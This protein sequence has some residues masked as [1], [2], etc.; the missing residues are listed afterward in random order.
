MQHLRNCDRLLTDPGGLVQ[1]MADLLD[2]DSD[3]LRQWVFARCV[4]EA[5]DHP[6]LRDVALRLTPR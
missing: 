2:L 4:R 5:I 3:R 1:R 6:E